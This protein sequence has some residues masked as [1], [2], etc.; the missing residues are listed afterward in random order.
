MPA[1][2]QRMIKIFQPPFRELYRYA[3]HPSDNDT[4]MPATL[5][6]IYRYASHSSENDTDMPATLQRMIQ[7]FQPPFREEGVQLTA[8]PV[9]LFVTVFL[10]RIKARPVKS[11]LTQLN[12]IT[13]K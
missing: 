9:R 6:R 12:G 4:N 13:I 8:V 11:V 1:T 2:L 7:I 3:S 5:Q 10:N